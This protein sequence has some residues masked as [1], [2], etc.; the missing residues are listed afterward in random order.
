MLSI[1][2]IIE[3][4]N[5]DQAPPVFFE[6]FPIDEIACI[7]R[8]ADQ[9]NVTLVYYK[10]ERDHVI[11]G[12]IIMWHGLIADIPPT[13]VLCDGDNGTPDLRDKFV[14]GA[15]DGDD[16]G[17]VGGAVNHNH[18]FTGDGH[19]HFFT[20]DGHSH[21]MA[22]AVATPNTGPVVAWDQAQNSGQAQ[23]TGQTASSDST[24]T[25]DNEDHLPPFYE[26]AFIMKL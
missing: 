23:A 15:P 18:G 21:P 14:V 1:T 3:I 9:A 12:G 22:Y 16:P 11:P 24:G 20:G 26:I 4:L 25:T 6:A 13:Y 19:Q 17:G 8:V 7:I 5:L 10:Y 2:H